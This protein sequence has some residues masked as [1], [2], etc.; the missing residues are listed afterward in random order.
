MKKRRTRDRRV[1]HEQ[2]HDVH[3]HRRAEHLG[4]RGLQ[5]VHRRAPAARK[6]RRGAE[7]EVE[8]REARHDRGQEEGKQRREDD[9]GPVADEGA[10]AEEER[11]E[12]LQGEEVQG[13]QDPGKGQGHA[14]R[15]HSQK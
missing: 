12:R 10:R 11:R 3:S 4:F 2:E 8:E 6:P 1:R 7:E 15:L 9:R 13:D 5:V 14:D